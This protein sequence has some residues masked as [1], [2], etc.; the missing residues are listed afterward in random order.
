MD[1]IYYGDNEKLDEKQKKI[2]EAIK[3]GDTETIKRLVAEP[4]VYTCSVMFELAIENDHPE[5]IELLIGDDPEFYDTETRLSLI[6]EKGYYDL[7][8]KILTDPRLLFDGADTI[9]KIASKGQIELLK[10]L[11]KHPNFTGEDY[12]C[13]DAIRSA[14]KNNQF[15][16]VKIL[17]EDGRNTCPED[18]EVLQIALDNDFYKCAGLLLK[19]AKLD[20]KFIGKF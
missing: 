18:C 2:C 3:N 10:L 6:I 11:L 12:E 8:K 19:Y 13:K 7:A 4:Y 9:C 16:C 5:Y 15:E 20:F 1:E 14:T 17:L